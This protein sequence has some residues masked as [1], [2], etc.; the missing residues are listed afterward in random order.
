[1]GCDLLALELVKN[2]EFLEKSHPRDVLGA[3]Y[4]ERQG[5]MRRVDIIDGWKR[6]R[7]RSS[8]TIS[9]EYHHEGVNKFGW[10]GVE[11]PGLQDDR[12]GKPGVVGSEKGVTGIGKTLVK[13]PP[14]VFQEPDMS[15]AF[16]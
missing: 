4:K 2:W 5:S 12:N 13:P 7:R 8:I 6:H 1:M 10:G 14:S 9:D 3:R 11:K 15:W 16:G